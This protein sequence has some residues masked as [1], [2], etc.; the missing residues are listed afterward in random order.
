MQ[1]LAD[2]TLNKENAAG[3]DPPQIMTPARGREMID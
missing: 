1:V 2:L 3:G